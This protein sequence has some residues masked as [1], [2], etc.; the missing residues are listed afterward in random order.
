VRRTAHLNWRRRKADAELAPL[1]MRA[2]PLPCGDAA[3]FPSLGSVNTYTALWPCTGFS[4]GTFASTLLVP[5]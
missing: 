5:D 3:Y 1:E 2:T 4:F